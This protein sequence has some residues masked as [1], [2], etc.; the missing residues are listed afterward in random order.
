[1][2]ATRAAVDSDLAAVEPRHAEQRQRQLGP[3]R[4]EQ[5]DEAEHLA[6]VERE[7]DV[8]EFAGARRAADLEHGGG[9]LELAA[10]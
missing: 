4:A 9:G 7:G 10:R 8:L 6:L 2:N 1:M 3:A 5:A